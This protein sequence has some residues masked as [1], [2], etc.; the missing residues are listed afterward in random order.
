V[1][2][3]PPRRGR[4][5]GFAHRG[6]RS[7]RR[8]NTVGAFEL[9]LRQGAT[10]LESDTWL[11][12]DGEVVLHHDGVIGPL[13]RRRA[14][15]AQRQAQLPS[16]IPTLGELYDRCGTAYELSLDVRD[17]AA[18][19]DILAA[20]D[21]CQATGRLWLCHDDVRVLARWRAANGEVRLVHSTQRRRITVDMDAHA[22]VLRGAGVDV[23]NLP[24]REW[25][26]DAVAAMHA[27]S[28]RVFGWGV[29]RTGDLRA[30]L[31]AGV[32]G[33]Y[34]DHVARMMAEVARTVV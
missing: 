7:G 31:D 28:V 1:D 15:S 33:V 10:G 14:L 23:L 19:G 3:L 13:W 24:F 16:Y 17:P 2:P 12:A 4:P 22:E 8:E 25:T 11:T 26:P 29:E 32:D 18:A 27:R 5:I 6:G 34:S 20:S 9:A 21:A 30:L